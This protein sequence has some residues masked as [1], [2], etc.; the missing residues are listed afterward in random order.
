M[1][2][3][4]FVREAAKRLL[5]GPLGVLECLLA[6]ASGSRVVVRQHAELLFDARRAQGFDGMRD[7]EMEPGAT[8]RAQGVAER[9]AE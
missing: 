4:L 7:P 6:V 3:C 9:L 5:T 1:S 2:G 8:R